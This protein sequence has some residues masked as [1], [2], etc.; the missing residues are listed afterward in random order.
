MFVTHLLAQPAAVDAYAFTTGRLAG[1]VAGLAGLAGVVIGGW[2]LARAAGRR[3]GRRGA[4]VALVAG[5]VGLVLGGVVGGHRRRW[6]GHRRR[7]RRWLRGVGVRAGRHSSRLAGAGA[8]PT[9]RL[10]P[11]Q[12]CFPRA[13]PHITCR[14]SH[15][16]DI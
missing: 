12:P 5:P 2:A 15:F 4:I 1:S 8:L 16:R 6:P 13:Q 7:N 9:R 10:I 14:E 3:G 11:A